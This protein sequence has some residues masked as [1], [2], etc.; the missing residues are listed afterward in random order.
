[1]AIFVRR[2]GDKVT[3]DMR[4]YIEYQTHEEDSLHLRM[5]KKPHDAPQQAEG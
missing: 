5:L 2:V 3:A 4:N 1:M